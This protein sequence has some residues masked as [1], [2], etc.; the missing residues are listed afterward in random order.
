MRAGRAEAGEI[1]GFAA[2]EF[3]ADMRD[4]RVGEFRTELVKARRR[5]QPRSQP[6]RGAK[7]AGAE[8]RMSGTNSLSSGSIRGALRGYFSLT[9]QS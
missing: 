7:S 6:S 9:H 5:K 3:V 8:L 1:D 4:P 2:R